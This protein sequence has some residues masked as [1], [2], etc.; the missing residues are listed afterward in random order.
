MPRA[1]SLLVECGM[2]VESPPL[3]KLL[4]FGRVIKR[5]KFYDKVIHKRCWRISKGK[6]L[7]PGHGGNLPSCRDLKGE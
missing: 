3:K 2:E 6:G 1:Q 5:V 4:H 7:H